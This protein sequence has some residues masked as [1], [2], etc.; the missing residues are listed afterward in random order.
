[1]INYTFTDFDGGVTTKI[2][3]PQSGGIILTQMLP[4]WLKCWAS[5]GRILD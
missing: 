5:M 4:G 2:A 3:N 1:M